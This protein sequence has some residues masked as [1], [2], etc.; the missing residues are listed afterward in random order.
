MG[1][2]EDGEVRAGG[3][4]GGVAV[5]GPA[6][7]EDGGNV[8]GGAAGVDGLVGGAGDDGR[9][10]ID[11]DGGHIREGGVDGVAEVV[12]EAGWGRMGAE[13]DQAG[14]GGADVVAGV[15]GE[16]G[17]GRRGGCARAAAWDTHCKVDETGGG[18]VGENQG[19][20]RGCAGCHAVEGEG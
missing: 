15:E 2:E 12:G 11:A 9:R 10:R 18:G 19:G 7:A 8:G 5:D 17:H 14:G 13:G 3:D 1:V 6:G 20:D 16:G 4:N